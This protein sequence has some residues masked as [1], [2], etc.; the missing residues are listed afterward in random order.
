MNPTQ[1]TIKEKLDLLQV[2]IQIG[3]QIGSTTFEE[4]FKIYQKLLLAVTSQ[5]SERCT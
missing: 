5:D 1:I 2:A 3:R 4:I